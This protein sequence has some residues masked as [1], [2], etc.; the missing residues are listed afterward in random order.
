LADG[1]PIIVW[2]RQDLRLACNPALTAAV[3]TGRP[4]VPLFV[5][6][7][8]GE[9]ALGGA[10]KWWLHHSL[11]SLGSDLAARGARLVLRKG[12]A[13]L[14]LRDLIRQTGAIAI[15]WNRCYEPAAIARDTALKAALGVEVRSFN[16]SLLHEPAKLKPA[17]S[18]FFK[19]FTPF[20]NAMSRELDLPANAPAPKRVTLF[21]NEIASD[22][23]ADWRLTPHAPDWAKDFPKSW[24]P[25]EQGAQAAL[26]RFVAG[27]IAVYAQSRDV[28]SVEATSR[29]SPHLHF[30][31]I[32]PAQVWRAVDTA[33]AAGE[34]D[35]KNA[36]KFKSEIGWREFSHHLLFHAPSL[37]E[38]NLRPEFDAFPWRDSPA[39]FKAWTQGRTGVPIVD[40]GMREL[41][42]TGWMHN[43][44]RMIVA[45]FLVKNLLIDWRH[46]ARWFWDTLVDADLANNSASW[47]WVA[48]SGADAAPY[49]RIFNPVL[50]GGKFDTDGAYVRKWVPEIRGLAHEDVHAPWDAD[51]SKL[52]AANVELGV[53]YPKPI[54]DL[55]ASRARALAAFA[56]LKPAA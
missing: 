49:F 37:P 22:A 47:Q 4:V 10:A 44:V 16:A 39:H 28:P 29:L 26:Q 31:E 36:H 7:E 34:V 46:G 18:A 45:S 55:G 21:S 54:V 2:F 25:G 50:Q 52:K 43:R 9:W 1:A 14:V 56:S 15:H 24:T 13:P 32:S 53:T 40:A 27:A 8:A 33:E 38:K 11:T 20:F 30:G 3:E 42:A 12:S 35:A 17:S 5:L 41:W 48:G 23:L 19:V 51:A 6:D